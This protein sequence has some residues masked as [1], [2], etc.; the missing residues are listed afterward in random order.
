[1]THRALLLAVVGAFAA[2]SF[3][4]AQPKLTREQKV[5]QDRQKVEREGFW[6]YNDLPKAFAE[7]RE[8]GKP[9]LVALR[10]IPCEECVKL[11]DDLV[12]RDPVVRPLLDKFVC[13]RVVSTNGLDL[14]L[15]QFD[16][17]QSFAAF[18][19]N[20]DGTVYGRFGTRSHRTAWRQDVSVEG[21]G[22]A[23]RGALE[24]HAEYPA[25][26]EVLAAKRG[27]QPLF[28]TPE[29]FPTLRDKYGPALD[30]K[31]DVVRS[32]IHCH[33]IG[34]ATRDYYRT[35]GE[36]IPER[37]LF[38]YPHPK[39]LGLILDPEEKATVEEVTPG[40]L[41]A[42]AG[43]RKGDE[44]LTLE[45]QPLLSL[46]DVQWVL[47]HAPPEGELKATVKR[48]GQT[49]TLTLTLPP[50]WRRLDDISWRAGSWPLRRMALGGMLVEDMTAEQRKE[51]GAPAEGMALRVRHVGQYGP[52]AAAKNAGFRPD[53]VIVAFGGV[54][55]R[56]RETDLLAHAVNAHKPGERVKVTV[57]RKGERVEMTL[58]MQQ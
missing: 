14:S 57:L 6:I 2:A 21:L 12:D 28:P 11:D 5:R 22:K 16:T 47:H 27:P 3:A 34:D 7:A 38:P 8:T 9:I 56:M 23:L 1:M 20:A 41:A 50:G 37:V 18:M 13:V 45:G 48:G 19:L 36:P 44:I 42:E 54:S 39:A 55:E 33:Q 49:R 40:S 29:K 51:F 15:F 10:C 43:F 31:G 32:C 30:Y 24:L 17:D 26:R 4:A 46:A 35:R 58:P 53:D 52:H 25:N